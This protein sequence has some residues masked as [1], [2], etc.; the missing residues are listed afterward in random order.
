VKNKLTGL[1]I[2]MDRL[3]HKGYSFSKPLSTNQTP[4]GRQLNRR[5]EFL[6]LNKS[7]QANQN[8]EVK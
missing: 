8:V 2:Q 5:T 1:G 7:E 3:Q 4:E 6:I